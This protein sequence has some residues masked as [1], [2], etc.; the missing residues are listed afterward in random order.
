MVYQRRDVYK[1]IT[2]LE[3]LEFEE[4]RILIMAATFRYV[5][6]FLGVRFDIQFNDLFKGSTA[7]DKYMFGIYYHCG[8]ILAFLN[9][10]IVYHSILRRKFALTLI[11]LQGIDLVTMSYSLGSVSLMGSDQMEAKKVTENTTCFVYGV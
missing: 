7:A 11:V 9:C 1:R 4:I 5:S 8:C 6:L 3:V 10:T 2:F